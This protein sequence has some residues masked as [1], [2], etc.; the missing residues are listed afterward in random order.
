MTSNKDGRV[1]GLERG[2]RGRD[3][4]SV[5]GGMISGRQGQTGMTGLEQ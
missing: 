4:E 1:A 3:D 2:S 5:G